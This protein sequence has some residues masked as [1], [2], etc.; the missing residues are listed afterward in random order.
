LL[1]RPFSVQ[2]TI[3]GCIEHDRNAMLRQ[4]NS[5]I[6]HLPIKHVAFFGIISGMGRKNLSQFIRLQ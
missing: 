5:D 4:E 1:S 6:H 2:T 3:G